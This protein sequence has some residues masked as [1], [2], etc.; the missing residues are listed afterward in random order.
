MSDDEVVSATKLDNGLWVWICQPETGAFY[1]AGKHY[2]TR[3]AAVKAGKEFATLL[4]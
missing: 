1:Q 2:K 4:G 3:A